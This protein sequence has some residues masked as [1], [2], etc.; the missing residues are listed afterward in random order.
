[1]QKNTKTQSKQ[2]NIFKCS[3]IC[4]TDSDTN[5]KKG[6]KHKISIKRHVW[7]TGLIV[8][9]TCVSINN[10]HKSNKDICSQTSRVNKLVQRSLKQRNSRKGYV[11]R[12]LKSQLRRSVRKHISNDYCV[13]KAWGIIV[14]RNARVFFCAGH[15]R[16]WPETSPSPNY[17]GQRIDWIWKLR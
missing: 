9:G 4:L 12:G 13:W 16:E 8:E 1:M 15:V 3:Q 10:W 14:E 2:E 17:H 11:C 5:V 6:L 7:T